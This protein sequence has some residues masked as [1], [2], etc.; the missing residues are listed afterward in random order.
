MD[1]TQAETVV[2]LLTRQHRRVEEL[3]EALVASGQ[4]SERAGLLA[5]AGDD[6]AVHLAAEEAVFYPAIRAAGTTDVLLESLEEHLSL[7][8]LLADLMALATVDETFAPKCKVLQ[9]QAE[10]HH[11]EE[12]EHLFPQV[13]PL[14]GEEASRRLA[15]A[16]QQHED[17]LRAAGE[18]RYRL[19]QQ[20]DAAEPLPATRTPI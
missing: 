5:R 6:L 20:T 11:H 8:R 13:G 10:H 3:L 14:L 12:E 1:A 4:P 9:E 2:Q 18:P 17:E 16:V 7:K 19:E 15:V